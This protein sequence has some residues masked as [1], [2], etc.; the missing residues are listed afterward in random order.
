MAVKLAIQMM[1]PGIRIPLPRGRPVATGLSLPWW[2]N[3]PLTRI[4]FLIRTILPIHHLILPRREVVPPILT[5]IPHGNFVAAVVGRYCGHIRYYQIWNEPNIYPEWGEQDV[6]P[7]G[8]ANTNEKVTKITEDIMAVARARQTR[9]E[10][11]QAED[12]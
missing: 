7:A 9:K 10:N 4:T 11:Q 1:E 6:D 5:M 2:Q 8:Y 3:R 12:L